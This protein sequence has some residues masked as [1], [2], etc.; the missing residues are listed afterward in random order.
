MDTDQIEKVRFA[1]DPKVSRLS[2]RVS[3]AGLLS[4]LGHN[5]T[6]AVRRVTGELDVV[7]GSLSE[8]SVRFRVAANS[9]SVQD[10]VSEND[11]REIERAMQADVLE[12]ARYAEIVFESTRIA[13]TA[14]GEGRYSVQADGQFTL[15]GVSRA[16]SIPARLAQTG[17]M[18]RAFGEFTLR[19]TDF[20]I[21]LVS[22]AGGTLKVKDEV[23][24][25]FD[26]VARK[27]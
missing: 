1:I 9:L 3:A 27:Q 11:R 23:Q 16:V 19:Q 6:I 24:V 21:K 4:A 2:I 25:S 18:L 22:V 7:F 5:P 12:T 10:D 13:A 17:D 14:E 15:H 26:M 8:S 20:G